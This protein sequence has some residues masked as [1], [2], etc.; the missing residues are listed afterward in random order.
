MKKTI[1]IIIICFLCPLTQ[2]GQYLNEKEP[3]H[4]GFR[5]ITTAENMFSL[6]VDGFLH[7]D[8]GIFYLFSEAYDHIP[9][10]GAVRNARLALKTEIAIDW[11][12]MLEVDFSNLKPRITEAYF[13][14][15][16]I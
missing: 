13:T 7:L 16:G 9:N 12:G 15:S 14:N 5:A 6:W 3:E 4:R 2:R 11:F 8:G 10:G 1:V